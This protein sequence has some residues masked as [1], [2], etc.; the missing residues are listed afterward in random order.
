[1]MKKRYSMYTLLLAS[2]ISVTFGQGLV[3]ADQQKAEPATVQTAQVKAHPRQEQHSSNQT[4][5]GIISNREFEEPKDSLPSTSTAGLFG[6][7]VCRPEK[8]EVAPCQ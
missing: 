7:D 4:T 1:M 5:S 2:I 3:T 8:I 6:G